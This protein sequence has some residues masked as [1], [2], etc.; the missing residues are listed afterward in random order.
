MKKL[1]CLLL[2]TVA[3]FS[4]K[5]QVDHE[6]V[7]A[8]VIEQLTVQYDADYIRDFLEI[9]PSDRSPLLY[10]V[11]DQEMGDTTLFSVDTKNSRVVDQLID[12]H[13][14]PFS[15]PYPLYISDEHSMWQLSN[16]SY[17]CTTDSTI[18]LVADSLFVLD[19]DT[20][21]HL[22]CTK[23]YTLRNLRFELVFDTENLIR[24][25]D[26]DSRYYR[27]LTTDIGREYNARL[28]TVAA[29]IM[30]GDSIGNLELEKLIPDT[31]EKFDIYNLHEFT[32]DS[33]RF[34]QFEIYDSY[35]RN[36]A[37]NSY[38]LMD[39]YLNSFFFADGALAQNMVDHMHEMD[40][41]N[42]LLFRQAACYTFDNSL[43]EFISSAIHTYQNDWYDHIYDDPVE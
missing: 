5:K 11:I 18:R 17:S 41:I 20:L 16:G 43:A 9:R 13:L 2:L 23:L 38:E 10:E 39:R 19:A 35:I 36:A 30:A 21:F 26:F 3:L 25:W 40:S 31:R 24:D 29:R 15:L 32:G 22:Q 1:L 33:I 6:A 42:P 28:S 8:S 34:E 12:S 7:R 4:C 14:M 37:A 27:N